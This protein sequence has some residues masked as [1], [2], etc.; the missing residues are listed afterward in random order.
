MINITAFI[1]G[2]C[3]PQRLEWLKRNVSYIEEQKF[4]F[5]K[6]IIAVDEFMGHKMPKDLII[7]FE[8]MG[9][10]VL[11]DSHMS[12]KESMSHALS[13]I[14]TEYTWYVEDDVLVK[15]PNIDDLGYIFNTEIDG[16]KCGW[17]SMSLGGT[18]FDASRNLIGDL[19]LMESQTIIENDTYRIFKRD[20]KNANAFFFEFPS[21]FIETKLFKDLHEK[22]K[23]IGGQ[24]EMALTK[25]YMSEFVDKYYKCSVVKKNALEILKKNPNKHIDCVFLNILDKYQGASILGGNHN[26]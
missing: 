19:E 26:Y 7:L 3:P 21:L 13:E 23:E 25:A 10:V 12:R 6:K 2:I 20:D 4:P 16:R 24:I 18:N 14:D 5:K 22:A 17:V 11:V 15:L 1:L 9:W 8:S